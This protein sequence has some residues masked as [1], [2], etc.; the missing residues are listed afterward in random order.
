[1]RTLFTLNTSFCLQVA[2]KFLNEFAGESGTRKPT[3]EELEELLDATTAGAIVQ[4]W[5]NQ[6]DQPLIPFAMYEDFATLAHEMQSAPFDLRR[7]LGAL[8]EALPTKNLTMLAC[9]LFHLNDVSVYSSKNGMDAAK[10]AHLFTKY[11]L[12][13]QQKSSQADSG[14]EDVNEVV[15]LVEEMITNVDTFIDE[16]EAQLLEDNRL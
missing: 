8:F 5:L 13:P 1:M 4:L 7:N 9:L 6:L 3:K 14:E 12:R 2:L 11:I 16:K 15:R 10:L